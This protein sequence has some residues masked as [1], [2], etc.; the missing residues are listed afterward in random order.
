MKEEGE[1]LAEPHL[2]KAVG[3]EIG[4]KKRA[5]GA[6]G[7]KKRFGSEI[8]A[9][10][11]AFHGRGPAGLRPVAGEIEARNGSGLSRAP[12]VDTRF[13]GKVAA[14]SLITVALTSSAPRA[15]G[16]ASQTSARQRSIISWRDFCNRS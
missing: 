13:W 6:L 8:A 16:K 14:A 9:A 7:A 3:R 15:R 5:R 1:L 10:D 12:A 4:L 11:S 2:N